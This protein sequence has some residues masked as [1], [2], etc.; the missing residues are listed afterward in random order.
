MHALMQTKIAFYFELILCDL[1]N[2]IVHG[3]YEMS[4]KLYCT[5]YTHTYMQLLL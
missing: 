5:K 4:Y 3:H 2:S 1:S